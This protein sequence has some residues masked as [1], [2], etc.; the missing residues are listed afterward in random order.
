MIFISR[1][2]NLALVCGSCRQSRRCE[3]LAIGSPEKAE[4]VIP[5]CDECRLE[6]IRRA[7]FPANKKNKRPALGVIP[8]GRS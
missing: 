6:L 7:S 5:I 1:G 3:L 8:G 2:E 4:H